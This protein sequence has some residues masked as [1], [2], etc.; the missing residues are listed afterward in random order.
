M[1]FVESYE[2]FLYG[3][4]GLLAL[5]Y[6]RAYL[7]ANYKLRIGAYIVERETAM[8][9]KILSLSM[10]IVISGLLTLVYFGARRVLPTLDTIIASDDSLDLSLIHI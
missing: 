1:N 9:E 7:A 4:L 6:L 2:N 10:L 3:F 8:R 5:W